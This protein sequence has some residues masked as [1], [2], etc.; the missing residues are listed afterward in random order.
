VREPVVE[1]FPLIG[2]QDAVQFKP[3]GIEQ[4]FMALHGPLP[5]A[6]QHPVVALQDSPNPGPL[7]VVVGL[8]HLLDH[9]HH[10][11]PHPEGTEL[12]EAAVDDRR[13]AEG[14][15]GNA[16]D[17][18]AYNDDDRFRSSIHQLARDFDCMSRS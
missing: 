17:Q 2:G 18:R 13:G 12:F 15:D 1:S 8:D 5:Q 4:P 3:H 7:C 10:P 6:L 14:A 9:S 11:P 16:D